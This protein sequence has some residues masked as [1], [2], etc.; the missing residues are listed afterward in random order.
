MYKI[1][2]ADQKE[3]GPVSAEQIIQWLK[4]GRS[5]GQTLARFEDGPWKPLSTFPE[6]AAVLPA[7]GP[8]PIVGPTSATLTVSSAGPKTNGL[9]IAGFS[10]SL[11]GIFCC[12]PVFATLGLILASVGLA[13][14]NKRPQEYSGTGLA[15]AAIIIALFDYV[16]FTVLIRSTDIL[17][18][19]LKNLPH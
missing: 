13:Q 17:D 14:I 12:G 6:F 1:V 15:W 9:V 7:S 3:Y 19:I 2:G 4:E 16:I 8:P 5:N 10:C 11:F 18:K